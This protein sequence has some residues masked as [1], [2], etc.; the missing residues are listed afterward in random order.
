VA[1][2]L[3]V[4]IAKAHV[5]IIVRPMAAATALAGGYKD[6]LLVTGHYQ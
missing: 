3:A 5:K 1:D 6:K 2:H 4:G